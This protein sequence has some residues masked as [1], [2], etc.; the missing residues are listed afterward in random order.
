MTN[1]RIK[2]HCTVVPHS[3]DVVELR[4]GA[5]NPTSF[6]LTDDSGSGALYRVLQ[7]LDGSAAASAIA[8]E[9]G[10]PKSDVEAL[11]DHLIELD[12]VETRASS[13]FDRYV[14]TC[15]PSTFVP[16]GSA[17]VHDGAL[18][19]GDPDLTDRLSGL[20][21]SSEVE[22]VEVLD[23]RSAAAEALRTADITRLMNGLTLHEDLASFEAWRGRFVVAIDATLHP[24]RLLYLNRI[25]LEL[26]APWLHAV[27]D[28]PFLIVGPIFE[29]GR[30]ACYDCFEQR[31]MLNA[32][33]SASYQ[34]YKVALATGTVTPSRAPILPV[35]T[36]VLVAHAALEALNFVRTGSGFTQGKALT[37]HLPTMELAFHDVLRLPSCRSC[38]PL[39]ERDDT[40][41]YF[42]TRSYVQDLL[43]RDGAS[44]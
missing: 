32:R 33:E 44:G 36:E 2:P 22:G 25:M 29:P 5:W 13:A 17:Q 35:V 15:L 20:L 40:E 31:V 6:T 34:R 41:L 16:A 24:L 27:V 21:R 42:D 26:G 43:V 23:Q 39:P 28:G 37:I 3:A 18:L 10:L 9:E 19:V 8:R 11:L 38:G 1:Y 7:R 30:S 12:V 4:I 14:E